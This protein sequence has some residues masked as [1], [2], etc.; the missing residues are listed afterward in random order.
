MSFLEFQ[1]AL[2]GRYAIE[3]ELGRGGMG[4]V[5]LARDMRLERVVAIKLL[6]PERAAD[7]TARERFVRE[8]RTAAQLSHP[9]I[10][11]HPRGG[12]SRRLRVLLY[13]WRDAGRAGAARRPPQAA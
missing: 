5:Y 12:R 6:P 7:P 13:R 1:T 10:I 4:I 11:P 8:A 9:H 3:R 2:V